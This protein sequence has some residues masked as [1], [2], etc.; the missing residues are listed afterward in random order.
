MKHDYIIVVGDKVVWTGRDAESAWT[1]RD[2]MEA[3]RNGGY[4]L[5]GEI[6]VYVLADESGRK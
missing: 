3:S 1:T 2:A 5:P 6:A 4:N